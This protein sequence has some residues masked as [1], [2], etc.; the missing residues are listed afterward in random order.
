MA[1][2]IF[3]ER[4][5]KA[6]RLAT[7]ETMADH[8]L[9]FLPD[10]SGFTEFVHTT[11]VEHSQHIIAEL[12]ELL[13]DHQDLGLTLEEIEGDAIFYYKNKSIPTPD[14]LFAQVE[15]MFVVFHQHLLRY[16]Q[17]RICNCGA[18]CHASKLTLKFIVHAGP[19]EF[20]S[21]KNEQRA[22]GATVIAAH[23]LMKNEVPN[24]E[25]LLISEGLL[26]NWRNRD[27]PFG[28]LEAID[29]QSTYDLGVVNYQYYILSQLRE[30]L[31]IPPPPT[32][33]VSDQPLTSIERVINRPL[34]E[35]YD[36]ISDLNQRLKWSAGLSGL[37]YDPKRIN[38]RGYEHQCLV[39]DT[40]L[41][42]ETVIPESETP[43]QR[44]Y[45][46]RTT[47]A[48]FLAE[49]TSL[50]VLQP[51]DD[52]TH[53]CLKIYAKPKS[54]IGHLMRPILR[55]KLNKDLEISIQKLKVLA[56]SLSS[57]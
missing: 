1:M 28:S 51:Q 42:L 21:I 15:R 38:R 19:L 27:I 25:Y 14:E 5:G 4:G 52:M 35:L 24:D 47:D 49:M 48:P 57:Q 23:R 30:G 2:S 44:T 13:I 29:G 7:L 45:G 12:L 22:Y 10:I 18:C 17:Q 39:N 11:A 46:E 55:R 20:I 34:P 50:F 36:L 8:S 53:L 43:T 32:Y 26:D 41:T 56:E 9:I 3:T 40:R 37:E 54:W 33:E 31:S 6:P 16:E